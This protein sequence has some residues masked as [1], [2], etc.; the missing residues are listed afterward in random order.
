MKS[1][2]NKFSLALFI[3]ITLL[4]CKR[5][6][7]RQELFTSQTIDSVNIPKER[8]SSVPIKNNSYSFN[9]LAIVSWNIQDL[10][11]SKNAEE[12]HQIAQILRDFDIVALQE[13]VAKD[14]G[15][16]QA[17][18]KIAD[19]LNRMGSKWDYRI[20]DPTKS[21]SAY[22]SERYAFLWK[23]SKVDMKSRA[24]LDS[25]LEE[26]CSREPF[27]GKFQTKKGT[28]PFY[29]INFH[30]RKFNDRPEE[31]IVYFIDYSQ[32]LKSDKIMILGD[33]NLDENHVVWNDF[34]A[35]GFKSALIN[36]KTT[37]K[38]KCKKSNY[39]KHA[40]DNIYFSIP[41]VEMINSGVIDFVRTCGNLENAR[42]LSDHLPVF[43]ECI[44][45]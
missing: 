35:Q 31:E 5:D 17:V 33:F 2:L 20:S 42:F 29:I 13:V 16:A 14:P 27:I 1:V 38:R 28:E 7:Q 39:L 34:Y 45:N 30:S 43:M 36:Q 10:G 44:I 3:A 37:L 19:E 8:I 22:S 15:G 12:L 41:N 11:K 6:V 23:T 32:R 24:Y 26:K 21:P 40:I 25:G 9:H 4:S 18:A